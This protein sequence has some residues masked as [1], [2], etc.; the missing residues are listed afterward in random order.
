L[1][2]LLVCTDFDG[3]LTDED[4]SAPLAPGF[5]S[6]LQSARKKGDVSWV[7]AT[8]RSWEGLRE[9]LLQHHAPA[10]PEWIV[11][12]E[13]E[14]HR[15]EN[16]EAQPVEAWNRT[17][18]EVHEALFGRHGAIL[19]RIQHEVGSHA[20]VS[21]IPDVGAIGLVADS[22]DGIAHA[23]KVVGEILKDRPEISTVRN[24]P[25]FRFAHADYHKGSCLGHVQSLLDIGAEDTFVAG[26]NLNDLSML[27]RI[28]GRYLAC[29]SNSHPEVLAQVKKEGG[30]LAQAPGGAGIAESL[31][32]FFR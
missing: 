20:D 1:K 12:V 4:P 2:P 5:F 22:E 10:F 18:T 21:V 29:P 17:C 23:E 31:H 15:V 16:R 32:F 6:W 24:G 14:I 27:R 30:Y 19:E 8:G 25:Y 28:Y 26:D 9:A 3:T 7:V 11:T 13:R